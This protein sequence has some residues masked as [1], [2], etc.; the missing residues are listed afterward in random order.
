MSFEWCHKTFLTKHGKPWCDVTNLKN[1]V[2]HKN[3]KNQIRI[4]PHIILILNK[5]NNP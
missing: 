5:N 1:L 3:R 2:V 4:E